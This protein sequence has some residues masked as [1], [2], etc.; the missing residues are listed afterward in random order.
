[1]CLCWIQS[2]VVGQTGSTNA[3][4][5]CASAAKVRLNI[6][7]SSVRV[8]STFAAG[9]SRL[10]ARFEFEGAGSQVTNASSDRSC[11]A[12]MRPHH[13]GE[14]ADCH[15]GPLRPLQLG[16]FARLVRSDDSGDC[17]D[18][19]R[20]RTA[21]RRSQLTA[22][23]LAMSVLVGA[24]LPIS[25]GR[26]RISGSFDGFDSCLTFCR[27]DEALRHEMAHSMSNPSRLLRPLA[28]SAHPCCCGSVVDSEAKELAFRG[29][30]VTF[31]FQVDFLDRLLFLAHV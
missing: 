24:V 11:A 30:F 12:F 10:F 1:M 5:R 14:F 23:D 19:T 18:E 27:S 21:S 16:V 31:F 22:R 29:N 20:A 25:S 13:R 8:A 17:F 15:A 2:L 28:L 6:L 7:G 26:S 3:D 4:C 9:A